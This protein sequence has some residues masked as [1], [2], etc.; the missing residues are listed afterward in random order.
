MKKSNL[1]LL[2]NPF[3]RIA[4]N[5]ALLTGLVAVVL[6]IVLGRLGGVVFDGIFSVHLR[7]ATW[8]QAFLVQ[9]IPLLILL[10]VM[11]VFARIFSKSRFRVI[12]LIGTLLMSRTPFLVVAITVLLTPSMAV[13]LNNIS[14]V[15]MGSTAVVP[16][17]GDWVLMGVFI[18][19]C[20]VAWIWFVSLVYNAISE[21]CN[22]RGAKG[23]IV[24]IV[25]L[26]VA[27]IISLITL[28]L[29]FVA[30]SSNV[31]LDTEPVGLNDSVRYEA[32]AEYANIN[33]RALDLARL[34]RDGEYG[35]V[36]DAFNDEMKQ[37]M[38]EKKV[39]EVMQ[40]IE[41]QYGP[42]SAIDSTV[43]NMSRDNLRMALVTCQFKTMPLKFRFVFDQ[44][45]KIAG[46][47]IV[48]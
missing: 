1:W 36:A 3:T 43:T 48:P 12:D 30:S 25:G 46:F 5:K 10:A 31:A 16:D 42:I 2:I 8:T 21:S 40:Q 9:F 44:S 32:P 47:F 19:V 38:P 20:L 39:A 28:F 15:L 17:V 22:L 18:L 45:D 41:K 37:A 7:W 23:V 29:L 34:L 24:T 35:E 6:T 14:R 11:F 26:A 13:S 27:E 33:R 4:G